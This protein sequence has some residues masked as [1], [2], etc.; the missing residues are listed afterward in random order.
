MRQLTAKVPT[1]PGQAP[2]RASPGP[3]PPPGR[4]EVVGGEGLKSLYGPRDLFKLL[5]GGRS[6]VAFRAWLIR[7]ERAGRFPRRLH[8]SERV[9]A[10]DVTEVDAWL[11]ERRRE[12]KAAPTVWPSP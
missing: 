5:G 11:A 3:S 1:A 2:D 10:W 8:L 9:I 12:R 4:Q 6:V 7:E